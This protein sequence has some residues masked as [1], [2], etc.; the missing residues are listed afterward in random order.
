[1]M[2]A[3][4]LPV[5]S[6]SYDEFWPLRD[7]SL[8]IN[9]GERLGLIGRNGAG[10]STLLK[11]IADLLQP[12]E[13]KI[14]VRGKV[15]ALMELGTGFHPEFTGRENVMSSFAYQGVTG[16]KALTL[17]DDALEFSELEDFIDKPI[18]TY[19]A[20]M[21]AR[22]A[23]A[24]ATAIRP[25]ILIID[26][27]LG[28]GDAYFAG[29]S[30]K[31]MRALTAEG[32]T[33]L[34]V[35]HDMSAVQMICDR[36]VW[37][38]RGRIVAD[39]DPIEI[40]RS[41][42][43]SIR[44]QEELRLRAINLKLSR[45]DVSEMLTDNETERVFIVRFIAANGG[46]PN[47]PVRFYEIALERGGEVIEK[48]TIGASAD[49]DRSQRVHLLTAKGY[50]DWGPPQSDEDG[51]NCRQFVDC[52]GQYRHAPVSIRVPLGLGLVEEFS[53]RVMHGGCSGADEL[54]C[55]V[56]DGVEYLTLGKLHSPTS[57]VSGPLSQ[58]FSFEPLGSEAH[59]STSESTISRSDFVY[60]V[61][62][63][64]IDSVDFV[65]VAGESR[66]VFAFNE[67]LTVQIH[68]TAKS[69]IAS[70]AFVVCFYGMDGRC[71]TQVVSPFFFAT[72]NCRSGMVE[73]NFSPLIIGKG[74]YIV[75]V[76]IFDGFTEGQVAG[77]KPLDVQDRQYRIKVISPVD[78]KMDRGLVVHPVA[79][80]GRSNEK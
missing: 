74:D 8:E 9:P 78:I 63:A 6:S 48:V 31:R 12:T 15:Q 36:A 55:Q 58:T 2:E 75:S 14:A 60:G 16:R 33:V 30:A 4:G 67:T 29:K 11:L 19:S 70:M 37:I 73:A 10:K 28:A 23:F 72:D 57:S 34:F 80:T 71:V 42:A 61:G 5:H 45:G 64:W 38:E 1:M 32:T 17:L 46:P 35:S 7:I 44:K 76:G 50:M 43:A 54:L 41:Y 40:G 49:D 59:P 77:E 66:R 24:A 52:N 79:W 26:E 13:G 27:I 39:G 20:G 18:K 53:V 69:N 25:E 21:Y 47:H 68:W 3:L 22:L 65:N 62:T 51:R 56:F